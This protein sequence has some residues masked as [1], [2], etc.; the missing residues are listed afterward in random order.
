MSKRY[1]EVKVASFSGSKQNSQGHSTFSSFVYYI[2]YMTLEFYFSWEMPLI[3]ER[4]RM[5]R[6]R[7]K[8]DIFPIHFC[9][10]IKDLDKVKIPNIFWF[11][12]LFDIP[13][14]HHIIFQKCPFII[15]DKQ[16]DG[17]CF[18]LQ[19]LQAS[20]S[21][22]RRENRM[23]ISLQSFRSTRLAQWTTAREV[24]RMWSPQDRD[25]ESPESGMATQVLSASG[26]SRTSSGSIS[27]NCSTAAHG[28][29]CSLSWRPALPPFQPKCWKEGK[30]V[31]T[32]K[33]WAVP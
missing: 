27:W 3:L 8:A 5:R 2:F 23:M 31:G 19:L 32:E 11:Y 30:T 29:L 6:K 16:W 17:N 15:L 12:F 7:K 28:L 10:K 21:V 22:P 4:R 14:N 25:H 18:L 24:A 13:E 9:S 33:P 20:Q 1:L 26:T